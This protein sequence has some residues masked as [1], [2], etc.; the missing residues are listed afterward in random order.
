MVETAQEDAVCNVGTSTQ[1]PWVD[2]MGLGEPGRLVAA[3][4]EASSVSSAKHDA[5]CGAEGALATAEVERATGA[6]EGDRHDAAVT[7]CRFNDRSR[8]RAV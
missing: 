3:R 2:V 7:F 8:H 1:F 6:I 5:L 4:P